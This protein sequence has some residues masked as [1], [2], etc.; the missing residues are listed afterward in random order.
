MPTAV[1]ASVGPTGIEGA[2]VGD[3][4]AWIIN[5]DGQ[6]RLT[7]N[8]IRKPLLGSGSAYPVPFAS[9]ILD[10]TLLVASDGLFKYTDFENICPVALLENVDAAA[11]GL[12]ELVR[13]PSGALWDDI[14]VILCRPVDV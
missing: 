6:K 7:R 12:I 14:A 11:A 5:S 8:Q 1:V 2:S 13:L 3:S 4:E 9:G 10:S